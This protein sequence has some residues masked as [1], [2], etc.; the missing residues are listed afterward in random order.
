MAE[1]MQQAGTN[2]I[3]LDCLQIEHQHKQEVVTQL[4]T[5]MLIMII[6]AIVIIQINNIQQAVFEY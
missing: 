5:F 6:I 2:Q 3:V 4:Q 1:V